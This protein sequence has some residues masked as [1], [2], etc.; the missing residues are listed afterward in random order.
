M[1][2]PRLRSSKTKVPACLP[3]N[4]RDLR[5][6]PS[7]SSR[8]AGGAARPRGDRTGSITHTPASGV[9]GHLLPGKCQARGQGGKPAPRVP[10]PHRTTRTRRAGKGAAHPT[11]SGRRAHGPGACG[12]FPS[13]PTRR[14][15]LA[16]GASQCPAPQRGPSASGDR[17]GPPSGPSSS[18]G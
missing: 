4:P 10:H 14:R 2:G 16:S 18:P 3:S 6:P 9:L 17:P 1:N 15:P 8:D 12:A 7:T 13:P 11:A 5:P